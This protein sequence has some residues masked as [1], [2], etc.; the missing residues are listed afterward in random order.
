MSAS[1]LLSSSFLSST[2]L[3]MMYQARPL[4][5]C[6]VGSRLTAPATT[7]LPTF[8]VLVDDLQRPQLPLAQ[9][10]L[11]LVVQAWGFRI[12]DF[13]VLEHAAIWVWMQLCILFV[14]KLLLILSCSKLLHLAGSGS[15][16]KLPTGSE[17]TEC[18]CV[19]IR[20]AVTT[21]GPGRSRVEICNFLHTAL[22][23]RLFLML[24]NFSV[25]PH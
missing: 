5:S 7:K 23:R 21:K 24:L 11:D 8:L 1:A 10:A 3:F 22:P 13:Q 20:Q 4:R 9:L 2:S 17:T 14:L 15:P 25:S 18:V 16:A 12:V 6:F 19:L